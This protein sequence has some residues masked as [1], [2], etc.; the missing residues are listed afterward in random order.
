M[1]NKEKIADSLI[2]LIG[3][4]PLLSLN[5]YREKY[6]INTE[7]VAKLE[8]FN[9]LGSAKDRVGAALIEKAE[10]DGLLKEGST[11]I[12]PTSGNTGV[13]L[14]FCA[15]IKGYK[16]ILTMPANMSKERIK[17]LEALGAEVVLTPAAD[18]M[19]GAIKKADELKAELGN[20][21]IPGQFVNP[22]NPAV[23]KRTTGPEI[24]RDTNGKID[25]FVAGV[26]TGGTI[27]GI[28]EAL[29]EYNKDI[30]IVA[31]EPENSAVL[32]GGK[33]GP[34]GL[35]GIGAGFVPDI[36]NT[37]IIDEVITVKD[38]EAYEAA[39]T[40]AKTDGL[41][42]GISSGAALFAAKKIALRNNDKNVRI[43]VLLPDSGERYL[44]TP[45]FG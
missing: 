20:A 44:S 42:M 24:L 38:E 13:G 4:T 19:P 22:E 2:D 28:G 45:L 36:L 11:I 3:N 9:P 35:M 18:G 8:Y 34:H 5:G 31:V 29:K 1:E 16:M 40:A 6:G 33:K 32:S 12:E 21:F 30:K 15:A 14:A 39:R 7:I 27:T 10:K 25:Y 26:G 41:L 23:H 37:D 43:V 17:L